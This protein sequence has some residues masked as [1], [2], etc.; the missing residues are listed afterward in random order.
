MA[1]D[2]MG[3]GAAPVEQLACGRDAAR[4]WEHAET[5]ELDEHERTCPHCLST[6]ADRERLSGLVGRMAAQEIPPPPTTLLEQVMTAV[7]AYLRPHDLLDLGDDGW[8]SR[9]AAASALRHVVDG[10]DG[11]RARS[12]RI[13]QGPAPAVGEPGP[14]LVTI[15]VTARFGVDLASVTARVRQVMISTGDRALGMP[16][17]RVDIQVVDVWD[18][19]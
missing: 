4:V 10:M 18:E 12:C 17:E 5:G 16:V 14:L 7:V 8:L 3:S 15:G 11:M 19:S 1:V 13:T 2:R 6:T 9:P